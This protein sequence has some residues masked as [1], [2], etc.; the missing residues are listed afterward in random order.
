MTTAVLG[1][2]LSRRPHKL[3]C[4]RE[5]ALPPQVLFSAWTEQFGRWFAIP[6][7]VRMKPELGLPFF[8]ETF[9]EGEPHAPEAH[10]CGLSE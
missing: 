5:M 10:A 3:F 7:S 8:F 2:D 6:E 9:F 4:E 1:P